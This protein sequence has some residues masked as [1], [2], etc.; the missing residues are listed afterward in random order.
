MVGCQKFGSRVC[1]SNLQNRPDI[2]LDFERPKRALKPACTGN[3]YDF[4]P[5]LYSILGQWLFIVNLPG[6][7]DQ[8][9]GIVTEECT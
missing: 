4:N 6:R 2:Q 9:Q 1:F 5:P 3:N 8:Q 7:E